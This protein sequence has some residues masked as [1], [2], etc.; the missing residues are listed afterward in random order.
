[1]TTSN[2]NWKKNTAL[3]L[4]SQTLSLFGTMLVQWAI[5]W[6]IVLETQSGTMMTLY[7]AV[8][9]LP[10]F[11][12][13]LFG[14]VWADRYNKKL[15]INLADG[16]IAFVS[17]IIALSLFA[18]HDSFI[19]L[20]IASMMRA[21]GQGIQ[22]PAVNALIPIIVP[23]AKLL[24]INGINSSIQSGIFLLSPALAASLMS[25]APLQTLF[26]IDVVT[27]AL[28]ITT[29]HYFVKV[30]HETKEKSAEKTS[31]FAELMSGLRY[32]KSHRFLLLMMIFS[33]IFTI[34]VSPLA[35]LTPLL[36]TRNFG[37]ELWLL[38]AIEITFAGG[39]ILGGFLVGIWC[40]RNKIFAIGMACAVAG[41][42]SIVLGVWTSMI[43]YLVL[44]VIGG[45]AAPYF[46]APS[47][48]LLQ[49]KVKPN[50][51]GRVLSVFVMLDSLAMPFGMLAFGPLAD[52]IDINYIFIG[53]GVVMLVLGGLYF[54]V[55]AFRNPKINH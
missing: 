32:I 2:I 6:H 21:L 27:A 5:M 49:E 47:M 25:F 33:A 42:I 9:I 36:T 15:L 34:F 11:F 44:M 35:I 46:N 45:I 37:P 12:T 28:A 39:M 3:F 41:L 22:Q 17:L 40:F 23:K 10:T 43:P 48:T 53:T 51:I 4:T 16:S 1:M 26:L 29:L 18:G 55:K 20:L 30:R 13:S 52:K 14:G 24:K 50:Y 38:S 19:L 31:H 8:A 7:V 54:V